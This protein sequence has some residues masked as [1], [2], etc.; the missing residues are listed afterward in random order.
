MSDGH[1]MWSTAPTIVCPQCEH[2]WTPAD[3]GGLQIDS[4]VECPRCKRTL[5]MVDVEV[6]KRWQWEQIDPEPEGGELVTG[7]T[8]EV[9]NFSVKYKERLK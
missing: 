3:P 5:Q 8:D 1:R 6:L 7:P 4:I 2:E 9:G